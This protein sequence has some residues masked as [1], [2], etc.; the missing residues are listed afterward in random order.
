M[1]ARTQWVDGRRMPSKPYN[2]MLAI[3]VGKQPVEVAPRGLGP[4][5]LGLRL[6]KRTLAEP[7]ESTG[8]RLSEFTSQ[9]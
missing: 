7:G 8:T 9:H 3:C 6:V 5:P 4:V 1:V 2:D